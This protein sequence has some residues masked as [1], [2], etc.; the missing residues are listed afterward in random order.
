MMVHD[1]NEKSLATVE[2]K[3][4]N[5][6]IEL[7]SFVQGFILQTVTGMV[8]SLKGTGEVETIELKISKKPKS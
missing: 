2:L 5:Q 1:A 3:V 6:N 4:N 7:N 8:K